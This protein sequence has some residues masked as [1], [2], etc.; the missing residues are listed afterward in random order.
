MHLSDANILLLEI[1]FSKVINNHPSIVFLSILIFDQ[2]T[3]D[4]T[5]FS[6]VNV[7]IYLCALFSQGLVNAL[8]EKKDCLIFSLF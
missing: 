1:M 7:P 2:K 4:K 6:T 5:L 8:L 3:V